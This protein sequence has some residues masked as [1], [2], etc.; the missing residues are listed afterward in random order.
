MFIKFILFTMSCH[1]SQNIK[2][3]I[4]KNFKSRQLLEVKRCL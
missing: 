1:V 2:G 4:F 3:K